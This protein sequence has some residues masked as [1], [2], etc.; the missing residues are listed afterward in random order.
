MHARTLGKWLLP[1]FIHGSE[2]RQLPAVVWIRCGSVVQM[3]QA[4]GLNGR[5]VCMYVNT[6]LCLIMLDAGRLK[7]RLGH[8]TP[9]PMDPM[10]EPVVTTEFKSTGATTYKVLC[11]PNLK[12]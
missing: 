3:Q 4:A 9:G 5:V 2:V 1:L 10:L 8:R 6:Y 11:L 12:D 7:S